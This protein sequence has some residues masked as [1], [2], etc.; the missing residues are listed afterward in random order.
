MLSSAST[1]NG[2]YLADRGT[3]SGQL[4]SPPLPPFHLATD[5][6][7]NPEALKPDDAVRAAAGASAALAPPQRKSQLGTNLSHSFSELGNVFAENEDSR[8]VG[9][10]DLVSQE[11]DVGMRVDNGI[12]VGDNLTDVPL[13]VDNSFRSDVSLAI[14][15]SYKGN[16]LRRKG[17]VANSCENREEGVDRRVGWRGGT[18]FV[19]TSAGL[20][21]GSVNGT[22]L[23]YVP[24]PIRSAVQSPFYGNTKGRSVGYSDSDLFENEAEV[25]TT[26]TNDRKRVRDE[27]GSSAGKIMG[28]PSSCCWLLP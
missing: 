3:V 6:E 11:E 16:S 27:N 25:G 8:L 7:Q 5:K 19:A 24:A 22:K 12:R 23:S 14:V 9:G 26:N 1:E 20:G 18:S 17:G 10:S 15:D 21:S 28:S 2:H 4:L 13:E